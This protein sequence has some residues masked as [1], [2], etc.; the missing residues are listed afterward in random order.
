MTT[1]KELSIDKDRPELVSLEILKF[2]DIDTN[3]LSDAEIK[4][5]YKEKTEEQ[6]I[7]VDDLSQPYVLRIVTSTESKLRSLEPDFLPSGD[8]F[9]MAETIQDI[10]K[11]KGINVYG[12]DFKTEN[13]EYAP[14]IKQQRLS[15]AIKQEMLNG[16]KR[17]GEVTSVDKINV[18]K[19]N[20]PLIGEEI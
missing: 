2:T 17:L 14:E 20:T 19:V 5:L 8:D 4:K 6:F 3:E 18:T 1:I 7:K 16:M 13:L 11:E 12:G 9:E 15:D 10:L